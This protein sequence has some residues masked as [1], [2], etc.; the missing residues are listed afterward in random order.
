VHC[1]VG[2]ESAKTPCAFGN[3]IEVGCDL[4]ELDDGTGFRG[5]VDLSVA[6]SVNVVVMALSLHRAKKRESLRERAQ[7]LIP[8]LVGF[9][10]LFGRKP[11][12]GWVNLQLRPQ[13]PFV[14]GCFS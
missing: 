8:A 5:R 11:H 7:H 10:L 14:Y 3:G 2:R 4:G 13:E 9:W 12:W 1:V 6:A